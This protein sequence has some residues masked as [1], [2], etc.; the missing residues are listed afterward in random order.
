MRMKLLRVILTVF[1]KTLRINRTAIN[2]WKVWANW[3]NSRNITDDKY[4]IVNENI[5]NI[6]TK[7]ELAFWMIR[8][9][10][11]IKRQDG[12]DRIPGSLFQTSCSLQKACVQNIFVTSHYLME[13][14]NIFEYFT[15]LWIAK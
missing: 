3:C 4:N 1:Q 14:M 11:E 9:V 2:A 5:E 8:L 12:K 13:K 10:L 7:E 15:P 6:V